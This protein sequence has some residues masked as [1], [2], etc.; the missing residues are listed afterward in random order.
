MRSAQGEHENLVPVLAYADDIA[1]I[2]RPPDDLQHA[3]ERWDT[4]LQAKDM[5]ISA[6]KSE[7]LVL[8]RTQKVKALIY[9]TILRPILIYGAETWTLTSKTKSKVQWAE[10]KSLRLIKGD[11]RLDRVRNITIQNSL[12][13]EPVLTYIEKA[14]LRW[15][16]PVK[17]MD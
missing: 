9:G 10:M 6:T 8:S 5:K 3:F 12:K 1:L 11:T 2:A 16:G 13:T 14:Q 17:R 7:I 4:E 15:D